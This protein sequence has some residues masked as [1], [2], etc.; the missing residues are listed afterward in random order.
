[1]PPAFFFFPKTALAT[2]GLLWVSHVPNKIISS[3]VYL[4]DLDV[5]E[6][7]RINKMQHLRELCTPNTSEEKMEEPCSSFAL[8]RNQPALARISP[9]QNNLWMSTTK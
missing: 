4:S 5:P 2:Q 3:C 1:M 9:Y 7:F 8:R 6:T